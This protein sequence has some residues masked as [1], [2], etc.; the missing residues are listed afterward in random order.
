MSGLKYETFKD[1]FFNGSRPFSFKKVL[2]WEIFVDYSGLFEAY[3]PQKT[4]QNPFKW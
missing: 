3:R 2:F 4:P 1:K